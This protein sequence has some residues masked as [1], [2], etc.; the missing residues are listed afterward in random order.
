[1]L[2]EKENGRVGAIKNRGEGRGRGASPSQPV[3]G[4][5][6]GEKKAGKKQPLFNR[7]ID[8]K[9]PHKLAEHRN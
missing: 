2:G 5:S 6:W 4:E 3:E 8:G 1:M 9:S 7:G